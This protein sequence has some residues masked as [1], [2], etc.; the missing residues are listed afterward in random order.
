MSCYVAI[1]VV[2][3]EIKLVFTI[4]C[5]PNISLTLEILTE[6]VF[7]KHSRNYELH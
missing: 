3:M 1:V 5:C 7:L 4:L 6:P 2:T